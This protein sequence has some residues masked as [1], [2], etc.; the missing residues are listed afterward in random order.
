MKGYWF[1]RQIINKP[2]DPNDKL[3]GPVVEETEILKTECNFD[4]TGQSIPQIQQQLIHKDLLE[5]YFKDK[6][7]HSKLK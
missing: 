3:K 2:K 4:S 1:K 6:N 5:D 7:K